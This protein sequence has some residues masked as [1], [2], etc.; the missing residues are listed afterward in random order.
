MTL[1]QSGN[2]FIILAFTCMIL[3]LISACGGETGGNGAEAEPE[4]QLK[5]EETVEKKIEAAKGGWIKL[6]DGQAAV[7][8][9]PGSLESDATITLTPVAAAPASVDD[10]TNP[11]FQLEEKGTGKGPALTKPALVTFTLE[12]DNEEAVIFKYTGDGYEPDSAYLVKSGVAGNGK[13]VLVAEVDSFSSRGKKKPN[14]KDRENKAYPPSAEAPKPPARIMAV[15]INDSSAV[16]YQNPDGNVKYD[17]H[18]TLNATCRSCT[19]VAGSS[20]KGQFSGAAELTVTESGGT[21]GVTYSGSSNAL[22]EIT[23]TL[24]SVGDMEVP[25]LIDFE[26]W[27]A[28]Q[29]V[30]D[31]DFYGVG[32]FTVTG[33]Q[34]SLTGQVSGGSASEATSVGGMAWPVRVV[35]KSL[36][37]KIYLSLDVG[38]APNFGYYSGTVVDNGPAD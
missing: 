4:L 10:V 25:P 22:G 26:D 15:S 7:Y 9:A 19:G 28:S 20:M 23:F 11:G 24:E 3:P 36:Q 2:L 16:P 35:Y 13:A 29:G 1:K 34:F 30:D 33:G 21:G 8:F 6:K 38:P 37:Q 31:L 18:L 14:Q 27:K 17:S 12:S 5:P 32:T